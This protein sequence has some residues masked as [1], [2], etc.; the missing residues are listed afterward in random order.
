MEE[1]EEHEEYEEFNLQDSFESPLY[2]DVEF[3][4][5]ILTWDDVKDLGNAFLPGG[6]EDT[7]EGNYTVVGIPSDQE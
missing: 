1:Y 5:D 6:F 3:L 2:T 4:N 7:M